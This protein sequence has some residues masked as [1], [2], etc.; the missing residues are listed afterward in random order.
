VH[1]KE[2]T[3]VPHSRRIAQAGL[4]VVLIVGAVALTSAVALADTYV[5]TMTVSDDHPAPGST[6]TVTGGGFSPNKA[7]EVL[8]DS[9]EVASTTADAN[10]IA[11]K[12]IVIPASASSGEH[13]ITIAHQSERGS[14]RVLSQTVSVRRGG[15]A[16]SQ[17]DGHSVSAFLVAAVV[18][19]IAGA[20]VLRKRV[21]LRR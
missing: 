4:V 15:S 1:G 14:R 6:V 3:Q 12:V 17:D 11:T 8:F 16:F 18:V 21:T 7:A 2:H 9:T 19:G 10:G 5:T 13:L 20:F